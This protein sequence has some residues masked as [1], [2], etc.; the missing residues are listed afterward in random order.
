MKNDVET[1][2]LLLM[3]N[4]IHF[5]CTTDIINFY[6]LITYGVYKKRKYCNRM[7]KKKK[8]LSFRRMFMFCMS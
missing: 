7:M 3:Y 8:I 4:T 1:F 5:L 6:L 2:N